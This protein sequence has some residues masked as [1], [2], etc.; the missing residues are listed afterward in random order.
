MYSKGCRISA[1]RRL[2]ICQ[3]WPEGRR[4]RLTLIKADRWYVIRTSFFR[5]LD[6]NTPI[7]HFYYPLPRKDVKPKSLECVYTEAAV[8]STFRA[9]FHVASILFRS[10]THDV[11]ESQHVRPCIPWR[12]RWHWFSVCLQAKPGSSLISNLIRLISSFC[13]GPHPN[14][15]TS[16]IP[17]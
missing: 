13:T 7:T 11:T 17:Q 16:S 12:W 8:S 3:R 10:W 1:W 6:G 15:R 4:E 5:L 9:V 2:C 14:Y